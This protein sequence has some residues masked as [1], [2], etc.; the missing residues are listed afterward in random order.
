M[1]FSRSVIHSLPKQFF[2]G[3]VN[4][5]F[6][7]NI[8]GGFS[9]G[10]SYRLVPPNPIREGALVLPLSFNVSLNSEGEVTAAEVEVISDP[11]S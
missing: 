1:R 2:T 3:A 6:P 11:V 8:P 4:F 7:V 9:L 5:E 10:A